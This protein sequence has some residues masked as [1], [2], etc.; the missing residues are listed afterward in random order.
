MAEL[1]DIGLF[2]KILEVDSTSGSETALAGLLAEAVPACIGGCTV[3]MMDV[4][5]GTVNLLFSRGEPRVV[6][7]THLDT[8]PPYIHPAF[9]EIKAGSGLPDGKTA[10]GDDLLITGRGS[11]DAKGQIISMLG[12]CRALAANGAEGFA[13]LLV[14]GEETGSKGAKAYDRLCR[15]GKAA[16][17]GYLIVGE[18]TDGKMVTASKGTAAF[19]IR[20]EGK[21]CHSGYPSEGISAI[22]RFVSF[23][24]RL[25]SVSFPQDGLLGT[26]TWNAGMLRSDNPR[27]ILSPALECE[28]YF[29]TTFAS[30][31][32]I[33]GAL[34]EAAGEGIN[35][36]ALGG[37]M[38]LEYFTVDGIPKGPVAFGSDAPHLGA[39]RNRAICGAGSILVAHTEREYVL[40]SELESAAR[41]YINIFEKCWF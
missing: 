40:L 23:M 16:G 7:C 9:S 29:R 12:A 33:E 6:F 10:A 37:D 41:T 18:P 15:E 26:T 31:S 5:D 13:L 8:V 1:I 4:G 27:N 11:C 17:A 34:R 36:E 30:H 38:P 14:A 32:L 39:F 24:N 28:L 3:R 19:K 22:D 25:G 2:R 20:I 21:P 35:I